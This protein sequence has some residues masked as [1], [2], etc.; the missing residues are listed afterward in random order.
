MR[1]RVGSGALSSPTPTPTPDD[2]HEWSVDAPLSTLTS[3]GPLCPGPLGSE[4]LRR[5]S[6]PK[7]RLRGSGGLFS[8]GPVPSHIEPREVRVSDTGGVVGI[9]VWYRTGS[10]DRPYGRGEKRR[11]MVE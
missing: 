5:V 3:E 4:L 8:F 2:R 11:T 7:L 1:G 10:N 6:V 9:E